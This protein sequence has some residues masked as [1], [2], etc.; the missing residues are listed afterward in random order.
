MAVTK[1]LS[2]FI[3]NTTAT[4]R[5]VSAKTSSKLKKKN[6]SNTDVQYFGHEVYYTPRD[7]TSKR[8][9]I[10]CDGM[11]DGIQTELDVR[12]CLFERDLSEL[13][14]TGES[15]SEIE[16]VKVRVKKNK[17]TKRTESKEEE[18]DEESSRDD[19]QS[20]ESQDEKLQFMIRC[21]DFQ[22]SGG[23]CYLLCPKIDEAEARTALSIFP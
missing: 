23:V 9:Y 13:I 6:V 4:L 3:F 5:Q 10:A 7:G 14:S 16:V 22:S 2:E 18:S 15:T 20:T 17:R 8:R 12:I 1:N 21:G 19:V 11:Q